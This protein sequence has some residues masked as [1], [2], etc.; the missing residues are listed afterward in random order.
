[1]N[2]MAR[3]QL[4]HPPQPDPLATST[5]SPHFWGSNI[6]LSLKQVG[7]G[8]PL[9]Q[10]SLVVTGNVTVYGS[11]QD[12]GSLQPASGPE[13]FSEILKFMGA[14]T[15]DFHLSVDIRGE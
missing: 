12:Q 13:E 6:H 11:Q 2:L 14:A 15:A 5:A 3:D 4:D 1:M 9:Q 10:F 8:D 7:G